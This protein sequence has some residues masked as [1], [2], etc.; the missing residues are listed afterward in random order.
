MSVSCRGLSQRVGVTAILINVQRAVLPPDIHA[1]RAD[2]R[3]DA[4]G[5]ENDGGDRGACRRGIISRDVAGTRWL[6]R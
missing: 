5:R 2:R 6:A 4:A 3:T 1:A